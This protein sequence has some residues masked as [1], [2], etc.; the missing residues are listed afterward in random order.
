MPESQVVHASR[1]FD[2]RRRAIWR[3][4]L[5]IQQR[6]LHAAG[7]K[8]KSLDMCIIF[9]LFTV[10]SKFYCFHSTLLFYYQKNLICTYFFI[11]TLL[12]LPRLFLCKCRLDVA[13]SFKTLMPKSPYLINT[14]CIPPLLFAVIYFCSFFLT[15]FSHFKDYFCDGIRL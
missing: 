11:E 15:S 4:S 8:F 13:I 7:G 10:S 9:I 2:I 6:T 1:Q 14:R 5:R 3:R 12:H